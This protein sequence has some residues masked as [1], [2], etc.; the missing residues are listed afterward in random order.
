MFATEMKALRKRH[1]A[2]QAVF[3]GMIGLSG[4]MVGLIET[5]HRRMSN[6]AIDEMVRRLGLTNEDRRRLIEARDHDRD[7]SPPL[8][9]Q[10]DSIVQT[11]DG[12]S[13]VLADLQDRVARL[14]SPPTDQ[15][16]GRVP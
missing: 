5:G 15:P 2:S 13:D 12:L 9:E 4:G 11:L 7:Q 3:A 10:V 1:G 16:G 6:E 8:S 14:E